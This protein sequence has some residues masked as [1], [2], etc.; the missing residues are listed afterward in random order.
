MLSEL[1][2]E[3]G[4]LFE[5]SK[6]KNPKNM[7]RLIEILSS[8]N[9]SSVKADIKGLAFEH[10]IHSYTRGIKND[11]GQFFT[12]RHIVKMMV[13]FIKPQIGETIYDPFCGTGGMLIECYRYINQRI[14]AKKDKN[15]LRKNTLFGRDHTDVARI[16]MMNMIMFGDGHSNITRGD[17]FSLLGESKNKYD[18]VITN[19]PFSQETDHYQGYPVN[20]SGEKNGDSIAV[21]HCLASLKQ[22]ETSR[23]AIIVP[24]GFLF[25]DDLK[26]ERDYILNNWNLERV[27]ELSPKCFQPYTEQQTAVLFLSKINNKTISYFYFRVKNDGFSQDG[28]RVPLPGENDID[29]TI[30]GQGGDQHHVSNYNENKFKKIDFL[31][32]GKSFELHEIAKVTTG[33][34]NI[35]P[36]TKPGDINNGTLP[37]MMVSDLAK[38]HIDYFLTESNYKLTK[39]AVQEKKPYLFPKETTLIATTGKASL[40]NHRALLA[41]NAYATS[42]L[43]GIESKKG[44]MHPY[45]LFYFFLHFD[46]EKITYDL[47]YPGITAS[48]LQKIRIPNYSE[49]K[50]NIIIRRISEAIEFQQNL[51]I[52]HSEII[53]I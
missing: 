28:Y 5:D 29:R 44:K 53:N 47:G 34:N 40:K 23:A 14:S 17:T 33:A 37:I 38:H 21:Q 31:I 15:I 51:K 8:F 12:P 49:K 30:D 1:K 22:N 35:S 41:V 4:Q 45:C 32:Q 50:Q 7:E 48:V 52:K 42:T 24:I 43:T 2:K 26:N 9:L 39:L 19:I 16:A 46:I 25:R 36:K 13:Q 10:F 18:I 27:I 20:P 6:I 11:L 3:H